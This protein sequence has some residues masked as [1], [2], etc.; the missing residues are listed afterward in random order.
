MHLLPVTQSIYCKEKK[1]R[2][3][4][5]L[6]TQLMHFSRPF[7]GLK[8]QL[9]AINSRLGAKTNEEPKM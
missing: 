1:K 5:G 8:A 6:N 7:W 4:L 3:F 2:L 9:R